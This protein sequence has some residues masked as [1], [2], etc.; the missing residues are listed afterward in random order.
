MTSKL[1]VC[2]AVAAMTIAAPLS[3]AELYKLDA[4]HSQVVFSYDHWGFS[5]TYNMFSGIN[6]EIMFDRKDPAASSVTVSMPVKELFTGWEARYT[7]FMD[8][9]FFNAS[10]ED[11]WTF[12]STSIEVTGDNTAKITGNLTLNDVTQEVV[13]DARMNLETDDHRGKG[14]WAG[15]DAT[16]TLTRS[17]FNLGFGVPAVSDDVE[18][19]ISIEAGP[20]A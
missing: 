4:S 2:A 1:S 15:F 5:R 17:D 7:H 12:T 13:L 9:D 19:I 11:V 3:A 14:K 8:A 6:G 18:L 20:N 16:T 10:D